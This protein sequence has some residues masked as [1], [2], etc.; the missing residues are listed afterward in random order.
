VLPAGI[1]PVS[2]SPS[3][4]NLA[5]GTSQ[6]VAVSV[7]AGTLGPGVYLQTLRV[8]GTNASG[9]PVTR[10]VPITF[11]VATATTSNEYVDIQGWAVF[12][13]TCTPSEGCANAIEGYAISGVYP[14]M[15]DPALR[16]GQVARLVPWN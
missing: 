7:N 12:R 2:V 14:D 10:L 16:R 13:I 6:T 4:I 9:Q 11:T 5:R 3:T 15:N 8:T 1:G